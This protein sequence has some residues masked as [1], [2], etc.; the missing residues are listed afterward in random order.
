VDEYPD[1]DVG[2]AVSWDENTS[3]QFTEGKLVLKVAKLR[4]ETNKGDV[5]LT[6]YTIN[7]VIVDCNLTID[8]A[9]AL[10]GMM[11]ELRFYGGEIN[12]PGEILV[13][14]LQIGYMTGP[15]NDWKN[16]ANGNDG[17][18][19]GR[20]KAKVLPFGLFAESF[21]LVLKDGYLYAGIDID[22]IY[23]GKPA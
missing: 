16:M 8:E 22:P 21:N 14:P 17:L 7:D 10:S 18:Q 15:F 20:L 12:N 9:G 1:T 11:N 5:L 23:V 13:N 3:I 4:I 2:L 6:D 19:S